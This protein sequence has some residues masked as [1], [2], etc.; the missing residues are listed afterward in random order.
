METN[1]LVKEIENKNKVYIK[2]IQCECPVCKHSWGVYI[3]P[4]G[5]INPKSM[6]CRECLLEDAGKTR[7]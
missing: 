1:E 7:E 4:N 3:A 6:I 5:R 2:Y